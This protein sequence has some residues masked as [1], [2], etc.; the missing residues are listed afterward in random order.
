MP[1]FKKINQIDKAKV[2]IVVDNDSSESEQLQE[3]S[4]KSKKALS[5]LLIDSDISNVFQL[6]ADLSSLNIEIEEASTINEL[7][8]KNMLDYP[9]VL[10]NLISVETSDLEPILEFLEENDLNV[11]KI[12]LGNKITDFSSITALK[13]EVQKFI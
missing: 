4:F 3:L 2:K 9:V 6:S 5:I 11:I 12:G 13:N 1:E 7:K 10:V 8:E